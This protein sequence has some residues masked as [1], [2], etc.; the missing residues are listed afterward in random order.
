MRIAER[1][2]VEDYEIPAAYADARNVIFVGMGGS[3]VVGDIIKDLT[4]YQVR[5]P[6]DVR[7]RPDLPAF[8]DEDSLV[9]AVSYS[10]NTFE[11]L[12]SLDEAMS[13]HCKMIGVTSGGRMKAT[14]IKHEVPCIDLPVGYQ[15]REAIPFMLFPIFKIFKQFGWCKED[16][17]VAGLDSA[18]EGIETLAEEIAPK[19][20][21]KLAVIYSEYRSVCHRFKS[22]LNENAKAPAQYDV[23]TELFHNEVNSWNTMKNFHAILLRENEE[24]RDIHNVIEIAKRLLDDSKYTEVL[25]EGI[26]RS[27]RILYMIWLGDFV[28]YYL[29]RRNGVD[30]EKV[31]MIDYI[32]DELSSLQEKTKANR[33]RPQDA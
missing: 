6:V 8:A 31:P 10:G 33:G 22:Q 3:G 20:S 1:L 30:P 13:R 17:D 19:L 32:K 9:V 18:R 26:N 25:A 4:D 16:I 28:S 29:A 15:P 7:R 14:L 12:S 24:R 27:T 5:K 2:L 11:T 21:R 23:V